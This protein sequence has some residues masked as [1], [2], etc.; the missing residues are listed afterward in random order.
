MN[1]FIDRSAFPDWDYRAHDYRIDSENSMTVRLTARTVG[2]MR[3]ELRLRSEVLPP[4]GQALSCP[5]EAIS[6]TFSDEGKVTKLCSGFVMDRLVGN[7]GG[8]CGV[9]AA[10]TIGGAPPTDWEVYPPTTVLARLIG[11]PVP[12]LTDVGSFLAPFPENV[13]IQLAKGIFAANMAIRDP[14]LLGTGFTFCGPFVGPVDKKTFLT[15]YATTLF[16]GVEPKLSHFRVDPYDPYRVWVD[17]RAVG[18]VNGMKI[19]VAPQATSFTFDDYG[20]CIRLTA[21]AVMDP[22][23]GK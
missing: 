5:P 20:V 9:M 22:S 13:M 7:T 23:I 4:N 15:Q 17:I 12:Q 11:R 2:T 1:D 14:D 19:D 10:A 3:G 16:G 18:I 8:L 21:G 6:I